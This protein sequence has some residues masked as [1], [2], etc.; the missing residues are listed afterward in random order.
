MSGYQTQTTR[1]ESDGTIIVVLTNITQAPDG[2]LPATKISE[3][4]SRAIP[5]QDK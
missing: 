2:E 1:R 5:L 4:I 3:L